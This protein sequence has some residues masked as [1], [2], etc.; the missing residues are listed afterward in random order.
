MKFMILIWNLVTLNYVVSIFSPGTTVGKASV[1]SGRT[2]VDERSNNNRGVSGNVEVP[3]AR[4]PEV[5]GENGHPTT[6]VQVAKS[7]VVETEIV[8][9]SRGVVVIFSL[10]YLLLFIVFNCI[11]ELCQFTLLYG[12]YAVESTRRWQ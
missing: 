10:G 1:G 8:S 9:S 3:P 7:K 12:V 5:A 11:I 2:G 4:A 6:S